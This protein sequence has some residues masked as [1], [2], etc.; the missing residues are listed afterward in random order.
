M[1]YQGEVLCSTFPWGLTPTAKKTYFNSYVAAPINRPLQTNRP[2][3]HLFTT[4]L[5]EFTSIIYTLLDQVYN[6]I[7]TTLRSFSLKQTNK[8][9]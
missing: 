5:P 3:Y 8:N 1:A 2:T 7:P 9:Q 6:K 4:H